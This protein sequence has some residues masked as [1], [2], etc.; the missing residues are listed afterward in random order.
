MYD[1]NTMLLTSKDGSNVFF[2]NPIA[3]QI[4]SE[5]TI[6][7]ITD[8]NNQILSLQ[9]PVVISGTETQVCTP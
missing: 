8:Q 3:L 6:G 7:T 2:E 4:P 5:G 9:R 1:D